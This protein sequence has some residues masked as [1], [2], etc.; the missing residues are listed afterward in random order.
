MKVGLETIEQ[1]NLYSWIRTRPDL[2]PFSFHIANE[3]K[4]TL[5]Y[6]GTL[7]RM[8]VKSGVSDMFIGVPTKKH[9]GMWLELKAGNNK[10]TTNQRVFLRDM[11]ANGYYAVACWGFEEA[12][13]AILDYLDEKV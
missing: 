3:R 4:C 1:I 5:S 13:Q 7:K 11:S 8:G 6:G 2:E 12:K 10:V 9:H